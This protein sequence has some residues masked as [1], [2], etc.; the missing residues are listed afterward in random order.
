MF[1][2]YIINDGPNYENEFDLHNLTGKNRNL[3]YKSKEELETVIL[4]K[5]L[6]EIITDLETE[7]RFERGR[8]T[9][10]SKL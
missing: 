10:Y 1:R 9:G 4:D 8:K 7:N 6:D 2:N 5:D 3:D